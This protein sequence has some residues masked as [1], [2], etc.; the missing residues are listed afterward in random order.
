MTS[1]PRY[2]GQ[3]RRAGSAELVISNPPCSTP[4]GKT[5]VSA[6]VGT[7]LVERTPVVEGHTAERAPAWLS[8]TQTSAIF[9]DLHLTSGVGEAL[10][11]VWAS[12]GIVWACN[13]GQQWSLAVTDGQLK[14][15][16]DIALSTKI[17]GAG[18]GD[19]TRIASLEGW[20]S[21]H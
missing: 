21:S 11:I 19:R 17:V 10:G 3:G 4:L 13:R 18:D 7:E 5:N 8:R 16:E 15:L 9:D 2:M 20:S 12:S 1:H 6:S 14:V